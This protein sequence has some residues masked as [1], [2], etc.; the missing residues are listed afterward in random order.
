MRSL[1]AAAEGHGAELAAAL[2]DKHAAQ[3]AAEA[4]S[5]ELASLQM[6]LTDLRAAAAATGGGSGGGGGSSSSRMGGGGGAAEPREITRRLLD[7]HDTLRASQARGG[8]EQ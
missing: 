5:L 1:C 4:A 7:L 6:M 3:E 2:R 8:G